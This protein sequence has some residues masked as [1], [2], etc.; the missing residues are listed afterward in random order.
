MEDQVD[1]LKQINRSGFPFQ[2]RVE[3]EIR[4][5]Q[6]D[7][8]WSVV[9]REQ[10]WTSPNITASGFIDVVLKHDDV[11]TFRLVIEC[12]RIKADD[13]RQLRWVFLLPDQE[14]ELTELASCFEVEGWRNQGQPSVPNGEPGR[15]ISESLPSWWDARIWDNVHLVPSSLQSEFCILQSDE[16]RRQPIL[17]SLA[18]EVLESIEGLAHEEVNIAKSQ[19]PPRHVRLFI[20][21][22][23]VTNAEI[24]VCRFSSNLVKIDD[25][26]LD[27][28]DVK[29]STVPFIRFRKSLTTNFL[30]GIVSN[31]QTVNRVR[32][33]TLFVV[34]A[35]SISEF[36]KDWKMRAQFEEYAIQKLIR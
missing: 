25:G 21:P 13:A 32:E 22:V 28:Q 19:N 27:S 36:L 35:T 31:L 14:S 24:A 15:P 6:A 11:S 18:A 7:H 30:Q 4:S 1:A 23:I 29:I 16:Q 12:K 20:F 8:H 26:T 34:N 17:E 3:Y 9:S 33:R 2:L 10:P 5:T